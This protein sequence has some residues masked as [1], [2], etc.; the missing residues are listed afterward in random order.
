MEFNDLI[1]IRRST[2]KYTEERPDHDQ[3]EEILKK[4]QQ[5]PSWKNLQSARSYVAESPEILEKLRTEGLPEFNRKNS[6]N[7]VLIVSTFVPGLSGFAGETQSNEQGNAWGAYDLGLHDA[8][9]V[10][11]ASDAGFDTLI[12]GIRDADA[13]RKLL[14]IPE[15][16]EIFSVIALGK[17]AQEPQLRKRKELG[18]V[19]KFF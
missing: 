13:I 19:A 11:A 1:K 8:Y 14:A 12:M 17:K 9:L 4:A 5:A 18:E 15:N 3:I 7:A 2:R 6:E 16:E 10:L